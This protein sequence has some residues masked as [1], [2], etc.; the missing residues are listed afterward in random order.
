MMVVYFHK[1]LN[2]EVFYVG[3]GSLHRAFD[4]Y[5]RT[6]SWKNAI[7]NREYVVQIV[8]KDLSKAEAIK[9]EIAYISL[10]GRIDKK[11]GTL[12]N[13]TAG[14]DGALDMSDETKEKLSK[15]L[16]GRK[17]GPPSEE[18]RRKISK[19]NKG[20]KPAEST[21]VASIEYMKT[22]P[23]EKHPWF[24]KS[25]SEDD[26]EKIRKTLSGRVNTPEQIAKWKES[27]KKRRELKENNAKHT[28]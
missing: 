27:M 20:T 6:A 1:Y 19:A 3:I 18:T 16:K 28:N 15:A 11:T 21:I 5:K 13:K 26:K 4:S 9:C 8:H 23:K 14:G 22:R 17:N 25:R 7:E 10:F 24:G 2:G 12:V